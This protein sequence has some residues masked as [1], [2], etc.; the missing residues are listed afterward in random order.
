MGTRK[1]WGDKPVSVSDEDPLVWWCLTELIATGG[2]KVKAPNAAG[3]QPGA[4]NQDA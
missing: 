1:Q 4:K 3:E 2:P